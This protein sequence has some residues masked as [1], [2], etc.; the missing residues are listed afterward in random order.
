MIEEGKENVSFTDSSEAVKVS[1]NSKE[2]TKVEELSIASENESQST[3][4]LPQ[5]EFD[6]P[7]YKNFSLKKWNETRRMLNRIVLK[8]EDPSSEEI[9]EES[10]EEFDEAK[11]DGMTEEFSLLMNF[12]DPESVFFASHSAKANED[13]E[14]DYE[15]LDAWFGRFHPLHEPLRPQTPPGP[16]LSPERV[17]H[18]FHRTFQSTFKTNSP[19]NSPI[20][21]GT[22]TPVLKSPMS[23]PSKSV[24]LSPAKAILSSP[25]KTLISSPNRLNLS[26]KRLFSSPGRSQPASPTKFSSPL[27]SSA[28]SSTCP[29]SRI[30]LRSKPARVLKSEP[31]SANVSPNDQKDSER[32]AEEAET[33][34]GNLLSKSKPLRFTPKASPLS[35]LPTTDTQSF[36]NI[37][38]P[39]ESEDSAQSKRAKLSVKRPI[40]KKT[41][42]KA[43]LDDIKKLLN[44]HNNRL[45]PHHN[46]R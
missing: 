29:I 32:P 5:F 15:E 42:E 46:K 41:D 36:V 39:H 14:T 25:N 10:T 6:A 22:F 34:N 24:T 45:R 19:Q 38:T 9:S 7:R 28:S 27:R 17:N 33:F 13:G 40:I 43:E 18:R 23:S 11:Q 2:D 20:N 8:I 4:F 3:V 26:P 35:L 44:Q 31:V 21:S 30:G 1:E 12:D 37:A 16:L